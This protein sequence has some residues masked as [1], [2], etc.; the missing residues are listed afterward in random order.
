V[1]VIGDSLIAGAERSVE[2]SIA[3][4]GCVSLVDAMG[5]RSLSAGWQCQIGSGWKLVDQNVNETCRPSGLGLLEQWAADSTLGDIVIIALGTNDAGLRD[6]QG[7]EM[8][9]DQAL[10]ITAPRPVMFVSVSSSSVDSRAGR[11]SRYNLALRTWCMTAPR[12]YI[13]EWAMTAAATKDTSYTDGIHLTRDATL[14]RAAFLGDSVA[15]LLAGKPLIPPAPFAT[16]TTTTATTSTT[17]TSTTVA[18]TTTT[19]PPTDTSVP[20]GTSVPVSTT[21]PDATTTSTTT[22]NPATSTTTTTTTI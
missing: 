14:K 21:T 16:T 11:L 4:A 10:A 1:N 7:W 12:C 5:G 22:A 13:A 19:T 20:D 3:A 18:A 2:Q 17:T 15:T 9:W 8:R 6:E